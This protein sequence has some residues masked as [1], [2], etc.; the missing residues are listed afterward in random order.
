M[1]K[2][3]YDEI[4]T[5]ADKEESLSDFRKLAT[6]S[7]LG[8]ALINFNGKD[9]KLIVKGA[10]DDTASDTDVKEALVS[11]FYITNIDSP[12]TKENY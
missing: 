10:S 3:V 2:D 5:L 8:S 4:K 9:Y 6:G 7:S 12:F 1:R 11:L